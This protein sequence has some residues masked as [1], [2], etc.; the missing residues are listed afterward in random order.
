MSNFMITYS[1]K[2]SELKNKINEL[3]KLKFNTLDFEKRLNDLNSKFSKIN[4]YSSGVST[5]TIQES[6]F[7][8]IVDLDDLERDI[9]KIFIYYNIIQ[10][11]NEISKRIIKKIIKHWKN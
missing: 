9:K 2:E 4:E 5:Q 7:R 11:S 3:K 1:D 10:S 6:Q 8:V